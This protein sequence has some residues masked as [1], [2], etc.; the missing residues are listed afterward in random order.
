MKGDFEPETQ[1]FPVGSMQSAIFS[2]QLTNT[3]THEPGTLNSELFS[4]QSAIFS[5]Q[6]AKPR[7][8][9]VILRPRTPYPGI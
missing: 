6:S 5:P 4:R 3:P 7:N 8:L 2:L 1:N 9:Q